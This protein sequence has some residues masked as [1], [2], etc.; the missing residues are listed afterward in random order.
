MTL[1]ISTSDGES[2]MLPRN[3]N[4]S[5]SHNSDETLADEKWWVVFK[6]QENR[7]GDE[8]KV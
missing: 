5:E 6:K 7:Y 2:E 8:E 1:V 4:M 3:G